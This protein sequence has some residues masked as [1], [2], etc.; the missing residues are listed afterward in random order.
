MITRSINSKDF[1]KRL[2]EDRFGEFQV[3]VDFQITIDARTISWLSLIH[4]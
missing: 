1:F 3:S 4:I 2:E